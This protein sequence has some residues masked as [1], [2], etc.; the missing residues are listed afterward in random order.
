MICDIIY[1]IYLLINVKKEVEIMDMYQKRKMRQEKKK[2]QIKMG[3]TKFKS[4]GI[5]DIWRKLR[6]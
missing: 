2:T 5:Q 6:D 1:Y 4:T 3:L